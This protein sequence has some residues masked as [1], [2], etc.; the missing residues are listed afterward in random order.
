MPVQPIK[1]RDGLKQHLQQEAERLEIAFNA[2]FE[3]DKQLAAQY[4]LG[5]LRAIEHVLSIVEQWELA[6]A[7]DMSTTDMMTKK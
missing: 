1:S 2:A 4:T 3:R 5:E 6:E 7:T